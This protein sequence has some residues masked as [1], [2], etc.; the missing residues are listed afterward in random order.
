MRAKKVNW[1]A[2]LDSHGARQGVNTSRSQKQQ[3]INPDTW[4]D[5]R[6]RVEEN[7]VMEWWRGK[8]GRKRFWLVVRFP[9]G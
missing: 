1:V 2:Q 3:K 8:S 9:S 5:E 6:K 4:G 7:G